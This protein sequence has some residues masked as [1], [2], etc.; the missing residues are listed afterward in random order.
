MASVS[1]STDEAKGNKSMSPYDSNATL[2]GYVHEGTPQFLALAGVTWDNYY[3]LYNYG[4]RLWDEENCSKFVIGVVADTDNGRRL[5]GY[6]RPDKWNFENMGADDYV[7]STWERAVNVRDYEAG[8]GDYELA[9]TY[10]RIFA[11]DYGME[12]S[13]A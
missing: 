6:V 2:V 12:I 7:V 5:V 8:F 11:K 10:E 3:E 13:I 4:K 9:R 1:E